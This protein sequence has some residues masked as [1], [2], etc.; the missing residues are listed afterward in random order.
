MKQW[1]IKGIFFFWLYVRGIDC[2]INHYSVI[3][4]VSI[5]VIPISIF[6]RIPW[7][8]Y[9]QYFYQDYTY[10]PFL[11]IVTKYLLILCRWP[12]S[13]SRMFDRDIFLLKYTVEIRSRDESGEQKA[14]MKA[15]MA[16]LSPLNWVVGSSET[17]VIACDVVACRKPTP[18]S[19]PWEPRFWHSRNS[20]SSVVF[21]C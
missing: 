8:I 1:R 3:E 12:A 4:N 2:D 18:V 15:T 11:S 20:V 5:F 10:V 7:D 6:V 13:L 19:Q 17:S 14:N 16:I 9:V 21:A